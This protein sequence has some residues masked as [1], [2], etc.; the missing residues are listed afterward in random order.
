[1]VFAMDLLVKVEYY[2][3][4]S[5]ERL[6]PLK[7]QE[8]EG[9]NLVALVIRSLHSVDMGLQVIRSSYSSSVSTVH[10][11]LSGLR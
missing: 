10:A 7:F 3:I 4:H 11:T 2:D 6:E 8:K 5:L 1:M 9:M